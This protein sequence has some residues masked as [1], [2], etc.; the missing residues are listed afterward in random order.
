MT[1]ITLLLAAFSVGA[2]AFVAFADEV[3][4]LDVSRTCRTEAATNKSAIDGC[5]ADE[6]TAREQLAKEWVQFAI[7]IR[8]NCTREAAGIIGIQSYVELLTC[9]QIAREAAKLPKE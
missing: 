5:M 8:T 7:S 3:P 1:K 2:A 4:L 9:L 6:R